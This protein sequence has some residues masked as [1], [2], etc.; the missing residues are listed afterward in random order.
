M[1]KSYSSLIC[2]IKYLN[3]FGSIWN[4]K[5]ANVSGTWN[6]F[7]PH[8]EYLKLDPGDTRDYFSSSGFHK[9][10]KLYGVSV[11]LVHSI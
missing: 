9:T 1:V 10:Y 3:A 5:A 7:S 8:F 4:S 11:A 2:L 6:L